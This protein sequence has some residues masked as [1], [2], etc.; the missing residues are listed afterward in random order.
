[1]SKSLKKVFRRF[2]R[3]LLTLAA[4]AALTAVLMNL[5]FNLLEA[6]LY[7]LRMTKGAQAAADSNIVLVTIDGKTTKA[8]DEFTVG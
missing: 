7:D 1:M 3:L 2:E 5:N 8:L 4:S 6:N